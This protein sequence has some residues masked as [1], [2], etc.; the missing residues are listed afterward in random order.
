MTETTDGKSS[1][2]SPEFRTPMRGRV[3]SVRMLDAHIE[4]IRTA[5]AAPGK[6]VCNLAYFMDLIERFVKEHQLKCERPLIE[7]GARQMLDFYVN[8][9]SKKPIVLP[10][11]TTRD[12]IFAVIGDEHT[13]ASGS[14]SQDH[15]YYGDVRV[16]LRAQGRYATQA[17]TEAAADKIWSR[18]N[19]LRA[20]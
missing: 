18:S 9:G 11:L 4:F 19:E 7:E 15:N 13:F 8:R 14:H 20:M 10:E 16:A 2:G 6:P 12:E 3:D 17:A 5:R 1:S